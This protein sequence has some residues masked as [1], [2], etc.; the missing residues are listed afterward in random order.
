M[1]EVTYSGTQ[2]RIEDSTIELPDPVK[3]YLVIDDVIVVRMDTL[4]K[5]GDAQNVWAFEPD[6]SL[7]W[8][9]ETAEAANNESDPYTS[10]ST[11]EGRLWSHNWNGY[12]YEID[13]ETGR[14]I[15]ENYVK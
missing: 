15:D 3:E 8:K 6:G 1:T 13:L 2:L 7:L 4:A 9:I 11:K 5:S 12:T 10:I 14:I